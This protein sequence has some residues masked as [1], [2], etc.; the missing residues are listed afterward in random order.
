LIFKYAGFLP[1]THDYISP[2]N[3]PYW[4]PQVPDELIPKI[5]MVFGTYNDAVRMYKAYAFEAGFD[6]RKGTTKKKTTG[7]ITVRYMLCNRQGKPNVGEVD[8]TD[9]QHKKFERRRDMFRTECD[10]KVVLHIVSCTQNF[11]VHDF[12]E[13]HNHPLISKDKMFMSRTSRQLDFSQE[14]MIYDLSNQN[15]GATKAYRILSGLQGGYGN[16]GGLQVDYKNSSKQLNCYIGGRDAALLCTKMR[17]RKKYVPNFTF[18]AKLN[19]T[20]LNACFWADETAKY[21]CSQFGDVVSVDATFNT[22]RFCMVFFIWFLFRK[23][24]S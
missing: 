4:T 23:L 18:E 14:R 3:T 17:E 22:N 2:G 24:I 1:F 16:R 20:Q 10:A 6:V 15:I 12:V 11:I 8:T 7:E 9:V 13:R 21:N 19:G 5:G